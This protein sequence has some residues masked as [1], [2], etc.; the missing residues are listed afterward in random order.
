MRYYCLTE[1]PCPGAV[2]LSI[3]ASGE[4]KQEKYSFSFSSSTSASQKH[5]YLLAGVGN[6]ILDAFIFL[7]QFSGTLLMPVCKNFLCLNSTFET[8]RA[9]G[10]CLHTPQ[11]AEKPTQYSQ[12]FRGQHNRL[13]LAFTVLVQGHPE[14][15]A[16]SGDASRCWLAG[17]RGGG[18]W[19]LYFFHRQLLQHGIVEDD[20]TLLTA[21][22]NKEE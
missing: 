18:L 22:N 6:R 14:Q 12:G 20:I 4:Q 1:P 3:L 9:R 8:R 19:I 17:W 16:T 11:S 13:P 7:E 10:H 5:L 2:Y 15:M 21:R